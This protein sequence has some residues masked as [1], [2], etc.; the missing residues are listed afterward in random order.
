MRLRLYGT[1]FAFAVALV[2]CGGGGSGVIPGMGSLHGASGTSTSGPTTN[3][4]TRAA[5]SLYVPPAAQQDTHR[6]PFYI[7]SG[8]QSFGVAVLPY[9]STTTP[10]PSNAQIFP[11]ATP[12]PCAVASGGGET[13]TL[14][15]T[16][17][18]GTD[19]FYVGA[20]ATASPGATT[21][22]ISAFISGA[23]TISLSPS[24]GA[25]PLSFTLN[26]VVYTVA[27]TV[28]SPDPGNT[29]NTEIESAGIPASVPLGITAEDASG[30][31]ILSA[32]SAPFYT[33]VVID[34]SPSSEGVTLSLNTSS[35]CGSSASGSSASIDCP[36]DLNAVVA[37][38]DGTPHPDPSDHLY[39]TF[40][41]AAA[42]QP[43]PA[44]ST[45]YI[46]LGGNVL[47]PWPLVTASPGLEF[48]T[49]Y[50]FAVSG[51]QLVYVNA[52]YQAAVAGTF[53]TSTETAGTA[54]QISQEGDFSDV[55]LAPDG[56]LWFADYNGDLDC[57]TSIAAASGSPATV[58]PSDPVDDGELTTTAV[59]TDN[60]G[61]I[62]YSAWPEDVDSP[63]QDAGYFPSTACATPTSS[64]T[65]QFVL[66]GDTQA[67]YMYGAAIANGNVAM[68]GSDDGALWVMNPSIAPTT[69]PS[70]APVSGVN[71]GGG[72][73]AD[74]L[75]SLYALFETAS[76]ADA[77]KLAP[78]AS[79]LS[80][81]LTLPATTDYVESP[82]VFGPNGG[83]ADRMAYV[84]VENDAVGIVEA[85]QSASPEP[86]EVFMPVVGNPMAVAY[87]S[88][89]GLYALGTD[90][91]GNLDM[92][93]IYNT[94]TWAGV[95]VDFGACST[96]GGFTIL[97][98][99]DSG[100][101]QVTAT[102]GVIATVFSGTDHTFELE[103]PYDTTSFT[104]TVADRNARTET[105]AESANA[106]DDQQ[107]DSA[108]RRPVKVR[109]SALRHKLLTPVP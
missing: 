19:V 52:G 20:Y 88:G 64:P 56:S 83:A 18:I 96:Y 66:N 53:T 24:P 10:G 44:P 43:S 67:D 100:P 38:Y 12:S 87:A 54:V 22:P 49:G 26:G 98:R 9:G 90:V 105:Y 42:S 23:I 48:G 101:F 99:G 73:T 61:N 93:R 28:P 14:T 2:A 63:P 34:A 6:K 102:N 15:V 60:A 72:A 46:V 86:L 59:M 65:P 50:L 40:A 104:I 55:A 74:A 75:G 77:E 57:Y 33:P 80:E 91:L 1:V 68:V 97:E 25:T 109:R 107:C 32:P 17:P 29:P 89:G 82:A 95:P 45:A 108:R 35:P 103:I 70:I 16:A 21:V 37:K 31:A 30:H 92:D 13:C 76:T 79:A 94:T 69:I 41:I 51:G 47:T 3:K 81:L 85:V 7:S 36:G 62:W 8:T 106:N 78:G 5:I 71:Y 11:V 84:D 58:Y 27:V 39:D 4:T